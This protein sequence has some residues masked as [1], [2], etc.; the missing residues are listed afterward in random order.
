MKATMMIAAT[1]AVAVMASGCATGNR[2]QVA[3]VV[4]GDAQG[5]PSPGFAVRLGQTA[6]EHPVAT[7]LTALTVGAAGYFAHDQGWFTGGSSKQD[8]PAAPAEPSANL[9]PIQAGGD[10]IINVGAG[11]A[12]GGKHHNGE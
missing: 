11:S 2:A 6:S 7:S 3:P 4:L 8:A 9:P 1:V 12:N 5:Q 10:V